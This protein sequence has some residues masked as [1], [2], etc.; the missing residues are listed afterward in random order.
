MKAAIFYGGGVVKIEEVKKPKPGP[1]EAIVKVAQG[2]ECRKT[3][4]F[5]L[6]R[7]QKL[8]SS[9]REEQGQFY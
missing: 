4:L 8:F 1:H 6:M 3:K 9:K 2:C 7:G 5:C